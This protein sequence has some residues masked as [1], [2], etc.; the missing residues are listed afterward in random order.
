MLISGLLFIDQ[1]KLDQFYY[2]FDL[3]TIISDQI[4]HY[5]NI[6]NLTYFG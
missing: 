1:S 6:F 3:I 4:K 5:E 2:Q